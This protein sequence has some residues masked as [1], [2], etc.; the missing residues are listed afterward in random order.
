MRALPDTGRHGAAGCPSE[1]VSDRHRNRKANAG[2]PGM[3]NPSS[4]VRSA[5][6]Y[7]GRFGF[8]F[9]EMSDR[10]GFMNLGFRRKGESVRTVAEAQS[11]LVRLVAEAGGLLP[12]MRV[13]DIGCGFLGPAEVLSSHF[14]CRMVGVDPGPV[15]RNAWHNPRGRR[16]VI[17]AAGEALRLPFRGRAF[18]RVISIESA[19]HYADKPGFLCEAARVLKPQGRLAVADILCRPSRRSS[20]PIERRFGEALAAPTFFD[21]QKYR[22]A[23]KRAGM[24][25]VRFD[26]LSDGVARTLPLW[27]RAVFGRWR[28]LRLLHGRRTLLK[29][30]LALAVVP[31]LARF[32]PFRYGLLVF[33][34]TVLHPSESKP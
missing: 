8:L 28:T 22:R 3:N 25:L 29:I 31:A 16:N 9:D 30:A 7:Y 12:G 13:L 19:F 1:R 34:C 5:V 10:S 20:G 15:Q 27:T 2:I 4:D 18:D 17:P 33:E 11:G 6:D 32:L 14:G 26:D 24:K 23:A 21:V